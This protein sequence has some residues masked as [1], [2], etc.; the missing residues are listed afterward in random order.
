LGLDDAQMQKLEREGKAQDR[1]IVRAPRA[2]IVD[3]LEIRAGMYVVA[4]QTLLRINGL[5]DVWLEVAVPEAMAGAIQVGESA[6]VR[7]ASTPDIPLEGHVTAVLPALNATTRSL[8]VRIALPNPKGAL[9]PGQSAQVALQGKAQAPVLIV[10]TEAVIRT[11]KRTL[12][13]VAEQNGYRPAEVMLGRESGN[14]TEI[15]S[16]LE[17]GQQVVASGQFLLDSEASLRGLK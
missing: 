3:A 14:N 1:Y 17:E 6:A 7:L 10:P 8:R 12:V 11:G 5:G 9:R 4:G 2:G 15:V 16:G 13:M